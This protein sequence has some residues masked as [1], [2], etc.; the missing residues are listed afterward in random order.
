M[1]SVTSTL[2][3]RGPTPKLD[4]LFAIYHQRAPYFLQNHRAAIECVWSIFAVSHVWD[5]LIDRDR[6][7]TDEEIHTAFWHAL[8]LLPTNPFYVQHSAVLQPILM[9]AIMN[10][11]AATT[12]ERHGTDADREIAFVLRAA[13]IDVLS[14]AALLVGG[15]EWSVQ[16]TPDIRRWMHEETFFE[17]LVHVQRERMARGGA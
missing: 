3:Q 2:D 8:V 9:N 16:V 12:M 13:Y 14:M 4:R 15:V 1:D 6:A 7:V 5:D 10:W 11:R 17:Y